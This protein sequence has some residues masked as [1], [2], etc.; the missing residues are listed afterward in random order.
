MRDF[1]VLFDHGEKSELLDPVYAPYGKLG[2]PQAPDFRPW[3]YSNFVQTLDGVVSLLGRD[4]SGAA[5]SQSE[6]DRWLM[7]LLRAHVD[8]LLLGVGTLKSETALQRPRPR[9]PVFRIVEPTLQQLRQKLHRERE[10]NIFV[11]ASGNLKLADYA[12][13]DGDKVD[14]IVVTTEQG[15]LLMAPQLET[16]PHVRMLVAGKG[17]SVDLAHAMRLLREQCGMKYVLCEGGPQLYGSMV[18]AGLMD[19]KFLTVSPFEAGQMVPLE[20]REVGST[21]LENVRPSIFPGEGFSC[22]TMMR[23]NWV[24]CRKCGDHQFHRF[25][26]AV[27]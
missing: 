6:E 2:F 18:R 16:H 15:S 12:V 4:S 17:G 9:G 21:E 13:F 10:C 25:R 8:G 11:T 22:E 7:D 26:R 27:E 3:I 1:Q 20:E 23:W 19:E 14:T 24:S 5:I